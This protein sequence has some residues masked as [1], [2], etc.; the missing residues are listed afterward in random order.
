MHY[1]MQYFHNLF[2]RLSRKKRAKDRKRDE[3]GL[4]RVLELNLM[5]NLGIAARGVK[6]LASLSKTHP[7]IDIYVTE[8][9]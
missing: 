3:E 8:R 6:A 7:N 9:Y 4:C 1:I 2:F 5:E